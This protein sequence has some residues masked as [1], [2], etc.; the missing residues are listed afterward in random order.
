MEKGMSA[1]A[2]ELPMKETSIAKGILFALDSWRLDR[3]ISASMFLRQLKDRSF[4]EQF[5][6]RSMYQ[7]F[8]VFRRL[9]Q[10]D[11]NSRQNSRILFIILCILMYKTLLHK[12]A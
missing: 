8:F 7:C 3:S 11:D 9:L 2:N 10:M 5:I 6:D 12:I 4:N 1:R